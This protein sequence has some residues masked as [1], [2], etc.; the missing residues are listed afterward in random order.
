[1]SDVTNL[2]SKMYNKIKLNLSLFLLT[3]LF[4]GVKTGNAAELTP[5][6]QSNFASNHDGWT[7][8]DSNGDGITWEPKKGAMAINY[9][10]DIAKD[11]WLITP[12]IELTAENY[13]NLS[14]DAHGSKFW[15]EKLEVKIGTANTVEAMSD[16]LLENIVLGNDDY[17]T[18]TK[19]FT[20]P[21]NG[22]YFIGFH[23][24]SDPEMFVLYLNNVVVSGQGSVEAP[25][26]VEALKVVPDADGAL[27]CTISFKA[28]SQSVAGNQLSGISAL[29]IFRDDLL[30]STISDATPGSSYSYEDKP[31]KG[32][33]YTYSVIASNEAGDSKSVAMKVLVGY[34]LPQA[35]TKVT[36]S[37]TDQDGVINVVW[38]AVTKDTKGR[39]LSEQDITYSIFTMNDNAEWD[40]IQSEI[41]NNTLTLRLVEEGKQELKQ[42]KVVPSTTA[43]DGTG[44]V[45]ELIPV[46]TPYTEL[47]ESFPDM[48]I[49][50]VWLQRTTNEGSFDVYDDYESLAGHN[51]QDG[52]NGYLRVYTPYFDSTADFISG[53][54]KLSETHPTLTF[55]TLNLGSTGKDDTNTIEIL[56][57]EANSSEWKSVMAP[58]EVKEICGEEPYKW[59]KCLVE[60]DEYAGK[61]VQIMFSVIG[62]KYVDTMI[63]N[64]GVD[65]VSETELSLTMVAPAVVKAGTRFN[66]NINVVNSGATEV[67]TYK[68]SLLSQGVVLA[69]KDGTSLKRD[70]SAQFDFELQMNPFAEVPVEYEAV[71]EVAGVSESIDLI[72]VKP[73][74]SGL[75]E[76]VGL[77]G[78]FIGN[79]TVSLSWT[80]PEIENKKSETIFESFEEAVGFDNSYPD[81]IFVD[82]DNHKV[83]VEGEIPGITKFVDSGSWW[84]WNNDVIDWNMPVHNAKTGEKYLFAAGNRGKESD[85]WAISPELSG[86]T[87]VISFFAQSR[88]W[89]Y[90]ERLEIYWSTGS[91]DPSDF[92]QL[93]SGEIDP[94]SAAWTEYL[95][96]LPQGAKRF[97]LRSCAQDAWAL[98]IDDI[99]Y[100]AVSPSEFKITGYNVYRDGKLLNE[101]PITETTFTD[102][103]AT[104]SGSYKVTSVYEGRGESSATEV[105][106]DNTGIGSINGDNINVRAINR[107]IYLEGVEN[108]PVR[109]VRADGI[110]IYNG[111]G[112]DN[113]QLDVT[114]GVYM[115]K[116]VN[117]SYKLIVR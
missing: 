15:P 110:S 3:S 17:T 97:A 46:G 112:Y 65:A 102:V 68:L 72:R 43:G 4:I 29:K 21:S 93:D 16:Y 83:F 88:M 38:P 92:K 82:L 1:M 2:H 70:E 19:D 104:S 78:E 80:K 47:H 51:S 103:E 62:Y 101:N 13:Y 63:D 73:V 50:Y 59:A 14:F 87:Q 105:Y 40:L 113:M 42:V 52:D 35:I 67:D 77:T 41:S 24:I 69:Q 33:Y 30:V 96:R 37:Y 32:G 98:M 89:T 100:E 56:V 53:L 99:Y 36:L 114:P 34:D 48:T 108:L 55:Y 115:I 84:I 81:W 25:G 44:G 20:V 74:A 28:P 7:I 45:S 22:Q 39:T 9:C 95:F 91:T 86:N 66:L 54:I 5:I 6:L 31:E 106:V 107:T 71:V 49:N 18:Y 60:L 12:A 23:G 94:V 79:N 11:D 8:I 27:S 90:P 85:N 26:E 75:P 58:R 117:N 116:V 111:E 10:D 64:I 61:N 57:K 76:V 109:V